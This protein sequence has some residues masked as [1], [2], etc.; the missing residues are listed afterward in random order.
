MR[1]L[2]DGDLCP[3]VRRDPSG[4]HPPRLLFLRN[5]A[6]RALTAAFA[7]V[8]SHLSRLVAA[9]MLHGPSPLVPKPRALTS[10]GRSSPFAFGTLVH[11]S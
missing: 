10:T 11:H 3:L 2:D 8:C 7:R 6:Q 4:R 9:P 5:G 1:L